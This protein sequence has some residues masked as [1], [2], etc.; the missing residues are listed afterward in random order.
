MF[1][2]HC[3]VIY[4]IKAMQLDND[5]IALYILLILAENNL[6]EFTELNKFVIKMFNKIFAV[7]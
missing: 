6:A 5:I 2:K 7:D 4:V 1:V 3:T